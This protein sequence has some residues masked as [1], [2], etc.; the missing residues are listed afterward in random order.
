[1]S[2]ETIYVS[3]F[4]QSRGVLKKEL[5]TH[6]RRRRRMRQARQATTAGQARGRIIDAVS[7]RER[8]TEA[9]DRAVPG[10]W[11]GD[12]LS[13]ARNSHI[14]TLV[15]R[16]SRFVLLVR[17]PGK[18]TVRVVRAL[19]RAVRALPAGLMASLTWDRGGELAAHRTF[20]VATDVHVYF[21]D[22]QS[23]WQRGTNENTNGLLRQ[24]FPRGTDLS[25]YTQAERVMDVLPK[26]LG[27]YGLTLHAD[28]TRVLPFGRPPRRQQ[29]GKGPAS[30][31]FLG[32]TL[33]WR[34]ARSGRWGMWCKTRSSRLQRAITV[35]AT[36]CRR[37]RHRPV[38]VQHAAL[39]RRIQGHFN[40]FGVSGNARSLGLLV[41]A[42]ER[43]WYKWLRCRSN[44]T[45]LTW[46]RFVA[47]LERYPLPV[48][49][50]RVRIWGASP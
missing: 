48:P 27:R 18:D 26:R 12:L 15:E 17:L 1:M 10:H 5:F 29:G 38:A 36:W 40:Y 32:F 11:E 45:R 41:D 6:L 28:K 22:P 35:A 46:P 33:Y 37:H 39:T 23:P 21:C 8:P 42:T 34:R 19:S 30:F 2:H 3:L 43:H 9:A 24:Y 7:I 20:T 47:L 14:A 50:I 44:R 49:R 13:G 4:V 31:D 25:T 16:R